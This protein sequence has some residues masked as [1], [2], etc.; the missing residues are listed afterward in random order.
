MDLLTKRC[1]CGAIFRLPSLKAR[2]TSCAQC[3]R[4]RAKALEAS[5]PAP[6]PDHAADAARYLQPWVRTTPILRPLGWKSGDE[7]PIRYANLRTPDQRRQD[8]ENHVAGIVR[9]VHSLTGKFPHSV[10][11]PELRTLVEDGVVVRRTLDFPIP[12]PYRILEQSAELAPASSQ[13]WTVT[14]YYG[15]QTQVH[16]DGRY[17]TLDAV[18][19]EYATRPRTGLIGPAELL[20][21]VEKQALTCLL[22]F[23]A[24]ACKPRPHRDQFEGV[25]H[26]PRHVRHVRF[27]DLCSQRHVD[28]V[29]ESWR[30]PRG[31]YW[32]VK[33]ERRLCHGFGPTPR[34][35][36]AAAAAKMSEFITV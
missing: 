4:A 12:Q 27:Y 15:E 35:A 10:Y 11:T 34:A 14:I 13:T 18:R 3:D 26:W 2:T 23:Y 30:S 6:L 1:S 21:A 29:V 7:V 22:A 28:L 31:Y 5:K 8:F 24:E 25:L 16:L 32:T 17:M 19:R 9:E 33:D 20:V 36:R